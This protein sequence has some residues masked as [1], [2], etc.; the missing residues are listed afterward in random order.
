MNA[1]VGRG[2]KMPSAVAEEVLRMVASGK[3]IATAA[4]LL[5]Y[6]DRTVYRLARQ[7]LDY[8]ERLSAAIKARDT[9][10]LMGC[11]TAASYRRGCRCR[12][13]TKAYSADVTRRRRQRR[14]AA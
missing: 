4:A 13:C 8:R 5:G 9:A 2:H 6:N 12:P 11:G 3:G 1:H 14:A 7:D 10:K